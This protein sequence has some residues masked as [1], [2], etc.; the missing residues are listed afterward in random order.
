MAKKIKENKILFGD[1]ND[2]TE[3]EEQKEKPTKNPNKG[4]L[5]LFSFLNDER[6]LKSLGITMILFSLFLLIAG[7]SFLL[8]WQ[9]DQSLVKTMT[10]G[11]FQLADEQAAQNAL[12]VLGAWL[13]FVFFYKGFGIASFAFCLIFTSIGIYLLTKLQPIPIFKTLR[14][15]FFAVIWLSLLLGFVFNQSYQI[16]EYKK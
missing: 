15:S 10:F 9:A 14:Y 2:F 16:L 5:K 12:G 6:F 1:V 11:F 3:P 7:L 8:T 4:T 13:G